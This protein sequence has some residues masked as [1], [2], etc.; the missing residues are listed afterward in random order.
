MLPYCKSRGG[1]SRGK[2]KVLRD[3]RP[4]QSVAAI[5][6]SAGNARA[7]GHTDQLHFDALSWSQHSARQ[8]GVRNCDECQRLRG[9]LCDSQQKV[10]MLQSEC[11]R[12]R[13]ENQVLRGE[14]DRRLEGEQQ[15]LVASSSSGSQPKSLMSRRLCRTGQSV[16]YKVGIS[17]ETS[18]QREKYAR[19]GDAVVR[20]LKLST[21]SVVQQASP[22]ERYDIVLH[23]ARTEG[24][25][26]VNLDPSTRTTFACK[27]VILILLRSGRNEAVFSKFVPVGGLE[28]SGINLGSPNEKKCIVQFL[29]WQGDWVVSTLNNENLQLLKS[30][31]AEVCPEISC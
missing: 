25:R 21:S 10:K 4:M 17:Y 1:R 31:M 26:T 16:T 6:T 13:Q 29:H 7:A 14:T 9:E 3:S 5:R 2:L 8:M 19:V 18:K 12:L 24:G 11:D 20:K 28:Y 22:E 15:T 30:L 23:F 27:N